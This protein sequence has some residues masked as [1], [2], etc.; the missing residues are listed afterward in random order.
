MFLYTAKNSARADWDGTLLS[1]ALDTRNSFTNKLDVDKDILINPVLLVDG[2]LSD[3]D[4]F[5][6]IMIVRYCNMINLALQNT[7]VK[8]YIEKSQ[9][10][11]K[12]YLIHLGKDIATTLNIRL[13]E[14]LLAQNI[15]LL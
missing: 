2:L 3:V 4:L 5:G 15:S 9:P 1:G 13:D 11:K 8:I 10:L 14:T 6:N 7:N 12:E